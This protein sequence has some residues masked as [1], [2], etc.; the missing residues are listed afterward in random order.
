MFGTIFIG[1]KMKIIK[2]KSGKYKI[3]LE[4]G[5]EIITYDEIILKY[6]IILKKELDEDTILKIN[7]DTLNYVAYDK[8]LKYITTKLRS[9]LEIEKYL[10]KLGVDE[11][12]KKNIIQKL[13]DN[14]LID[15]EKYTIAFIIDKINLSNI[16]PNKIKKEL[17]EHNIDLDIIE[18]ELNKYSDNIFEEKI[19]KYIAKK[20]KNQKY[21]TFILKQKIINDLINNGYS[22]DMIKGRLDNVQFDNSYIIEKDYN[23]IKK[24]LSNKFDE[25]ELDKQIKNKLILKGYKIEEINQIIDKEN[26]N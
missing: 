7:K 24:R 9:E 10:N 11:I 23:K 14:K 21:S 20:I 15:D 6:N 3:K 8:S 25:K 13:K 19:D 4:D 18:K 26:W 2:M 5:R 17:L 1:D 12:L 22:L 16:G